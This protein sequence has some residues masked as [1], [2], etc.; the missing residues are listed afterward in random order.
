MA[1]ASNTRG[2]F[3]GVAQLRPELPHRRID[4]QLIK[5]SSWACALLYFTGSALFN[6]S[7]RHYAA[8]QGL[9]LSQHALVIRNT[10]T[11]EKD[12]HKKGIPI[13][14]LTEEDV[15]TALGLEYTEPHQRDL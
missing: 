8:R 6:R 4:F 5:R 1:D 14:C 15:F 13:K 9:S 3:K 10:P 2:L 7:M 12:M 11:H